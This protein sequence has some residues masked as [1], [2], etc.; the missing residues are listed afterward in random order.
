MNFNAPLFKF[1][2]ILLFPFSLI[3]GLIIW[4]RNRMYDPCKLMLWQ[5]VLTPAI[6]SAN[7]GNVCCRTDVV[8]PLRASGSDCGLSAPHIAP[9][10]VG[11]MQGIAQ[12]IRD[13]AV[14]SLPLA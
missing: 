13:P 9:A 14:C 4:F 11:H 1:L 7:N 10:Y 2:R 5:T 8:W 3:Y 12:V 6:C